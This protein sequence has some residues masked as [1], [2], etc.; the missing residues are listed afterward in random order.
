MALFAPIYEAALRWAAHPKAPTLL[1][2]LSFIEAIFFPVP[3]EVMLGPMCLAKPRSGFWYA[4]ISTVAAVLG[5]LVGYAIGYLAA[6]W[7]QGWVDHF[8]YTERFAEIR[9]MAADNGFWML[10]V[11]G[12]VPV[13]F[14]IFTLASGVVGMPLLPFVLG[15]F[16]G[17]AKRTYLVA[18]AIRLGGEK[19]ERQLHKHVETLGWIVAGLVLALVVWLL[20]R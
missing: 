20:L 13:P 2:V 8:G 6:D 12:F 17:R 11:A 16:V 5:A 18:G 14:K 7:V 1:G 9:Q 4:T 3:P 15:A 10:L 19:M